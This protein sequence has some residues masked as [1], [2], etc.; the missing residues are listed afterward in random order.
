[1]LPGTVLAYQGPTYCHPHVAPG[2]SDGSEGKV[3]ALGEEKEDCNIYMHVYTHTHTHTHAALPDGERVW[4]F[5]ELLRD[6]L[7]SWNLLQHW[8]SCRFL[9]CPGHGSLHSLPS[10]LVL[11]G[12]HPSPRED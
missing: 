12:P 7:V 10:H 1:M 5:R 11:P 9:S 8:R 2:S 4:F 6:R 3:W